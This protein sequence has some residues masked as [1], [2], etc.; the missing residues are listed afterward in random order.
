ML[1]ER[2]A[3]EAAT[4]VV[5][6][7][8]GGTKILAAVVDQQGRIT[9]ESKFKTRAENGHEPLSV[10]FDWYT[11]RLA[12]AFSPSYQPCDSRNPTRCHT[13]RIP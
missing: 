6:M 7:D 9:A 11:R 4:Y 10:R 12:K 13:M 8:L 3:T 2:H 1:A 5:G